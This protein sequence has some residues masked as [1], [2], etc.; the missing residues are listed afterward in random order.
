MR[1]KSLRAQAARTVLPHIGGTES[2]KRPELLAMSLAARMVAGMGDMSLVDYADG[3]NRQISV[4]AHGL[5]AYGQ[6]LVSCDMSELG[7]VLPTEVR[8]DVTLQAPHF[9]MVVTAASLHAIG[10]IEWVSTSGPWITGVVDPS[11]V[12]LHYVAGTCAFDFDEV[13]R[14]VSRQPALSM[15]RLGQYDVAGALS[16]EDLAQLVQGV[17]R[18]VVAGEVYPPMMHPVCEHLRNRSFVV[19]VCEVG[20][21]VLHMTNDARIAAYVTFDSPARSLEN[22][23]A[24]LEGLVAQ[25]SA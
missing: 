23:S 12:H 15:D 24:T 3:Q 18:G 5:N 14:H 6:W 7:H 2:A 20:I 22:L 10:A 11:S 8:V 13:V 25:A 9:Q 17:R 16:E 1:D 4:A 19:D 21:T